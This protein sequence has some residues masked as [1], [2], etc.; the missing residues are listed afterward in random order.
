MA[1]KPLRPHMRKA[2]KLKRAYEEAIREVG[3]GVSNRRS[4]ELQK[5]IDELRRERIPTREA[6]ERAAI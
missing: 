3:R 5:L 6:L 1:R 4:K 2:L